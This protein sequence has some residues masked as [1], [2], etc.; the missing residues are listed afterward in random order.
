MKIEGVAKLNSIHGKAFQG[1]KRTVKEKLLSK[2]L[3]TVF[4]A[5]SPNRKRI[6]QVHYDCFAKIPSIVSNQ[7]ISFRT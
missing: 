7:K 5:Q 1:R 3:M 2:G 6:C 4:G